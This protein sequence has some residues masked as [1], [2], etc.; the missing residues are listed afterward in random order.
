MGID[1]F[2]SLPEDQFDC[3][4]ICNDRFVLVADVRLDNREEIIAQVGQSAVQFAER[5]DAAILLLAWKQWEAGC[6]DKIVGDFA[7]AVYDRSLRQLTLA[8]DCTGSKPLCYREDSECI[9]FASMPSG[10]AAPGRLKPDLAALSMQLSDRLPAGRTCFENIAAVPPGELVRF[11]PAGMT[12]IRYWNPHR[13][14]DRA[15]TAVQS[16]KELR[17]RLDNSVRATIRRRSS[18]LA[19]HLSSGYD[20]S[21]VAGTAARFHQSWRAPRCFDLR[22]GPGISAAPISRSHS[23]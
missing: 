19:T 13:H 1:L 17:D 16:A 2:S 4:P 15:R 3:Q 6:L 23:R 10:V 21:A 18:T 11:S 8:R 22:P 9:R 5:S 12:Q 20:S 14:Y 7:F